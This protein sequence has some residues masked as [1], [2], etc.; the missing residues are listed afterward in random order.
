MS[1]F[2]SRHQPKSWLHLDPDLVTHRVSLLALAH[3]VSLNIFY[4]STKKLTHDQLHQAIEH[5]IEDEVIVVHE[6][7]LSAFA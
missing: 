7:H 6:I 1:I 5:R 3:L 2:D 4:Y